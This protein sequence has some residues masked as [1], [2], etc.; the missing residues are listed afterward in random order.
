MAKLVPAINQK[1]QALGNFIAKAELVSM[2]YIALMLS[3][4]KESKL[5]RIVERRPHERS[6]RQLLDGVMSSHF[7]DETY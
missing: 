3:T 2:K 5:G 7:D 6:H 1:R 4:G